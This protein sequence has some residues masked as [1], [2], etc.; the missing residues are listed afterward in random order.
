MAKE[1]ARK[2][3]RYVE[4]SAWNTVPSNPALK[5]LFYIPGGEILTLNPTYRDSESHRGRIGLEGQYLVG[6]DSSLALVQEFRPG[7]GN[8]FV[9]SAMRSTGVQ[10]L[11]TSAASDTITSTAVGASDFTITLEAGGVGTTGNTDWVADMGA[12]VGMWVKIGFAGD[13]CGCFGTWKIQSISTGSTA[14]D[15][16]T[17]TGF[18]LSG[19][20]ATSTAAD[21]VIGICSYAND[22]QQPSFTFELDNEDESSNQYQHGTGLVASS[23][24]W[25]IT[26]RGVLRCS[27]NFIG[28]GYA[29]SGVTLGTGSR[30]STYSTAVPIHANGAILNVKFGSTTLTGTSPVG[31]ALSINN[32]TQG[33]PGAGTKFEAIA[34]GRQSITGWVDFLA[35]DNAIESQGLAEATKSIMLSY[36]D[37]SAIP[38]IFTAERVQIG[39]VMPQNKTDPNGYL[40]ARLPF[41][42]VMPATGSVLARIDI[43][44]SDTK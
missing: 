38:F 20:T 17:V 16:I 6:E 14:N 21:V 13:T 27:T 7:E 36:G 4:E 24:D 5:P 25:E 44:G 43:P 32:N 8:P 23:Q 3:V 35:S 41:T 22:W 19:V 29:N 39:R 42:V 28:G 9:R 2:V 10:Y 26:A 12:A 11:S 1:N 18:D 33:K 15:T 31:F 37:V 40:I 34:H 30:S